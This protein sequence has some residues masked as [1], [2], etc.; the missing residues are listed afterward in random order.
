MTP[1][2]RPAGSTASESEEKALIFLLFDLGSCTGTI[3]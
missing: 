3:F 2:S 1:V